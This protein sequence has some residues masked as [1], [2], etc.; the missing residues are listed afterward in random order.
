MKLTA[1]TPATAFLLA[2]SLCIVEPAAADLAVLV[3]IDDLESGDIEIRGFELERT[4]EVEIEALALGTRKD[5]HKSIEL[6]AAWILNASSREVVWTLGNAQPVNSR[7]GF[8]KYDEK[9]RLGAGS[10]EVYYATYPAYRSDGDHGWWEGAARSMARVFGWDDGEDYEEAVGDLRLEVRGAGR[11]TSGEQL[12]SARSKLRD[13]ALVALAADDD[14]FAEN[15]GFVLE[16]PMELLVYAVGELNKEE[17]YDYGWIIDAKTRKRV[18]TFTYAGSEPAGVAKKNRVVYDKVSLPAGEYAA[19]FVTD[20]SHSPERWNDLPPHDPSFWGITLWLKDP[21]QR[22]F[23][24]AFDYRH[25]PGDERVIVELTR[26]RD[27][28]HRTRGF[29]LKQATDV[30][31]YALGAGTGHGMTDYGWIMNARSRQKVWAM[32]FGSTEPGGGNKKNRL[33]DVVVRLEPGS[34]VVAFVTDGSHAYRDWNAAP[35]TYQDR[36][37]ISLF[38]G[39][40]FD[41]QSV[42]EYREDEDPGVLA[43]IAQVKSDSHR[44]REFTLDGKTEVSVYALGEGTHGKMSDYAWLEDSAGKVVWEMTYPMTGGAGGSPKNRL[45]Q[46]TL[47]LPPGDYVLHYKSDDSHAYRDWNASPPHDP[48]GWGVQVA[49]ID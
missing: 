26:M 21:Q 4:Q 20:D 13:D 7:R 39:E 32:E 3:E 35:P 34:Y 25:L 6:A 18:W 16:R 23:A 44:R 30:R 29:T 37:G 15:R 28:E 12:A 48:D 14:A 43:R 24:K 11:A 17:G 10:Y 33:A 47:E 22:Q 27:K 31:I 1:L 42:A 45:Y 38:G 8:R 2:A 41:P 5:A 49:R 9:V 19:Y 40:D 36:W 46:G